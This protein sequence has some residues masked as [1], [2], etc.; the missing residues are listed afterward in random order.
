MLSNNVA[1]YYSSGAFARPVNYF[2][3][4]QR[5]DGADYLCLFEGSRSVEVVWRNIRLTQNMRWTPVSAGKDCRTF[6]RIIPELGVSRVDS[7]NATVCAP[8]LQS[9]GIRSLLIRSCIECVQSL[10]RNINYKLFDASDCVSHNSEAFKVFN[11]I[12]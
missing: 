10:R 7:R 9:I 1:F 11:S 2:A 12:L 4:R 8:E 6:I 5:T 3:D